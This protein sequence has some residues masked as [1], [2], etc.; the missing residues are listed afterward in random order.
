MADQSPRPG[1]GVLGIG[2][3][4]CAVCCAGPVLAFLA[5]ASIGTLIGVALFG[6]FGLAVAAVA[7]I[8]YLRRRS[9]RQHPRSAAVPV[10]VGR[11]PNA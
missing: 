7:V 4:A 10:T 3:A 11:K 2:A 1:F 8:A 5:A 9:G 6:M